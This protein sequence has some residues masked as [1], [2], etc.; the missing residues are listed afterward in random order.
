VQTLPVW[1]YNDQESNILTLLAIDTVL[2]YSQDR[3]STIHYLNCIGDN[4][5][6]KNAFGTTFQFTGY[7]PVNAASMSA[8]NHLRIG[9]TI[10]PGQRTIIEDEADSIEDFSG[11]GLTWFVWI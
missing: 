4:G 11:D 1:A 5:T 3:F 7:R 8:A 6:G 9:G 2:S 10:E